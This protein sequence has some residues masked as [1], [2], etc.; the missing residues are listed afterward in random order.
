MVSTISSKHMISL[1]R[2]EGFNPAA[3]IR[4]GKKVKYIYIGEGVN[5]DGATPIKSDPLAVLGQRFFTDLA[6]SRREL[7]L[8]EIALVDGQLPDKAPASVFEAFQS[9]QEILQEQGVGGKVL[10]IT[11]NGRLYPVPS[12]KP[13]RI[14]ISAP[15]GAGKST[16]VAN[17]MKEARKLRPDL[18]I[19]IFSR[20]KDDPAFSQIKKLSQVLLDE[21]FATADPP[22]SAEDLKD[23][24]V[25]FDDYSQISDKTI[26][27]AVEKL[28]DDVLECGRHYNISCLVTSHIAS[29]YSAT[30]R[31]IQESS[32]FVFFPRAGSSY[33]TNRFLKLYVG[34]DPKTID[35]IMKLPSR[36]VMINLF[37]PRYILHEHGAFVL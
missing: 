16:V 6:L 33:Q 8:L 21:E 31:I 27:K 25:I 32:A 17:Y 20:V 3:V 15:S 34:L 9:A 24:L 13:E 29:N 26:L 14:Y 12:G 2:S 23:S 28:R 35:K 4:N 19:F 10:E 30:R 11:D 7:A 37:H 5:A 1:E 22:H 18:K 36:W